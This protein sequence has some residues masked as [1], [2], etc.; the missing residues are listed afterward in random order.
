MAHR[1]DLY[2]HVPD[3]L[4]SRYRELLE[5]RATAQT[6][7][8]AAVTFAGVGK[9]DE[10]DARPGLARKYGFLRLSRGVCAEV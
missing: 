4:P 10:P 9:P 5:E 1:L 6:S 8:S 2:G 3:S 7:T